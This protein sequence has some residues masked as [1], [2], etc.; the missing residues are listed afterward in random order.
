MTTALMKNRQLR[1]KKRNSFILLGVTLLWDIGQW[2]SQAQPHHTI[3]AF[4]N[5]TGSFS[6]NIPVL[7]PGLTPVPCNVRWSLTQMYDSTDDQQQCVKMI[8]TTSSEYFF[9]VANDLEDVS[10]WI[11]VHQTQKTLCQGS[12]DTYDFQIG[13]RSCQFR[14]KQQFLKW[15]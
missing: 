9:V 4:L 2:V 3:A 11:Y 8:L 7:S 10:T 12:Y 1:S 15:S 13:H 5:L 14:N 6:I